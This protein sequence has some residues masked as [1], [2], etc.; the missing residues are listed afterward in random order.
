ML[1]KQK[2]NPVSS[3]V[4]TMINLL[5]GRVN[6]SSEYLGRK[7][8]GEG[9]SLEVFRNVIIGSRDDIPKEA[10]T[11]IVRFKL[12]NMTPKK[13]ITFSK[14]MIPFFIGLPGFR[15]KFWFYNSDGWNQGVYQWDRYEDAV[16]YSKSFAVDFMTKRSV[17]GSVHVEILRNQNIYEYL[18]EKFES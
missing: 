8:C 4:V 14:C 15:G 1:I 2:C 7:I 11:F 10:A 5:K 17:D 12:E 13:N 16:N 9:K 6:F 18:D 3:A